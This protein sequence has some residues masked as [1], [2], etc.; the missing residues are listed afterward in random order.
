VGGVVLV[1]VHVHVHVI[2]GP[3]PRWTGAVLAVVDQPA[4]IVT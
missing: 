4:V 2:V 3:C 1:L